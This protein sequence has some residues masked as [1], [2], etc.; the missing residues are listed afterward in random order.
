MIVVV[1]V[2]L[3]FLGIE[4]FFTASIIIISAKESG[5]YGSSSEQCYFLAPSSVQEFLRIDDSAN[6]SLK[7]RS[8][9]SVLPHYPSIYIFAEDLVMGMSNV[10]ALK[11]PRL[12]SQNILR[13]VRALN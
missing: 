13:H 7:Q 11:T 1:M 8:E 6:Q 12:P 4:I 2:L 10:S 5:S 9:T 3:K